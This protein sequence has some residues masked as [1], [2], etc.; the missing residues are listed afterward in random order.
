VPGIT[1]L[2]GGQSEQEA[3]KNLDAINKINDTNFLITFSYGRALQQSALKTWSKEMN[4]TKAIHNIFNQRAK[5]NSLA[6]KG[7]WSKSL[8]I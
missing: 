2:S 3:S 5:M 4:N 1:F 6:S 8:E 7:E